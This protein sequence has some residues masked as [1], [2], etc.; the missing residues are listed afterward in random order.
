MYKMT[1]EFEDF[2]GNACKEDKYFHLSEAELAEM[3]LST[4]GGMVKLLE[5]IVNEQDNSKIVEYFKMLILKS[6]GEKSLDGK[7]FIKIDSEGHPLSAAF[8]QTAA[9]SALFMDL[10]TDAEKAAAFVNGIL[11]KKYQK[12]NLKEVIDN[13]NKLV[14]Q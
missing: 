6:Y 12:D 9:Y 2:D 1:I 4:D 14:Q 13:T 7:S 10:A 11:P 8:S 3:E 5:K